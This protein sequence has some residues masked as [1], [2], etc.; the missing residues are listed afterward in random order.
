MK[1]LIAAVLTAALSLA[2]VITLAQPDKDAFA[3][4]TAGV[5][6]GVLSVSETKI[7]GAA[8][9]S[10]INQKALKDFSKSFKNVVN[11]NWYKDGRGYYI[12]NFLKGGIDTKV[13]YDAKGRWLYNLLT[14][15]EDKLPFEIRDMVKTTYYDF[16]ILVCHEYTIQGGSVYVIKMQD[17]KTLKTVKIIAGEMTVTEDY[18]RG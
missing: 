14:Y 6:P 5:T 1:T 4:N 8:D 13:V 2:S 11:P 12:A 16:D 15:T 17:E 3:L 18:V 9:A 10:A 7:Y